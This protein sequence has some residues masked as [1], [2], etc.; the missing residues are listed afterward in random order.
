MTQLKVLLVPDYL[1]W[2]LGTWAKQIV[3]VGTQHDYYFFS[4]Q[5][6]PYHQKEWESLIKIV[7]VV[8]VLS[9]FDFE[10]LTLPD[11]LPLVGSIHHVTNWPKLIPIAEKS[12]AI[13]MVANE[14]KEFVCQQGVSED[15]LFL[16]NNGVEQSKFY[17]LNNRLKA[18]K[19][20]GIN[21]ETPLIGYSAKYTSNTDGRKG[22]NILLKALEKLGNQGEKFGV[23][24]TGPGWDKV[25]KEIKTYGINEVYYFPFLP[26]RLMPICYNALDL[27]VVTSK[28]EGGPVPV[29]N[30]MACGVPVVT[31]P[32][33]IV[34]DYLE[35]GVN[36]LIVPKDDAEATANAISRLLKS[37]KLR[38]QLAKAGLETVDNYL[39]WDKTLAG[40]EDLYQQVWEAKADKKEPTKTD[41]NPV[42]Q[43]ERALKIDSYLWN[44]KLAAKGHPLEGLR[45]MV[46]GGLGV[47]VSETPRL[48]IAEIPKLF[49]PKG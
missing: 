34:K 32:V 23:L 49:K 33:G 14:W 44:L 45:G 42:K 22:V 16:F 9:D 29:L 12:D 37:E 19:Q 8:H 26:D 46:E 38:E 27:Y 48:A 20:L 2:I 43:R 5:M 1:T 35:D 41:I 30:C 18:R 11:S 15:Q 6:L 24:I 28:V 36:G 40:I 17:P 25:V 47:A 7:D 3:R 31:T 10:K 39:T 13:M 21:S 4:Q